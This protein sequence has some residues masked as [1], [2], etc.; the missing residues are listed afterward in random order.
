MK[1]QCLGPSRVLPLW[2]L[3]SF[4]S[5]FFFYFFS[6]FSFFVH[7]FIF[8]IFLMFFIFLVHFSEEKSF[9]FSFFLVFLSNMFYSRHQNQSLTVSSEVGAPKRC[10]VPDDKGR[11]SLDWVGGESMIQLPR[12]EWRILACENGASP[13]CI[14][15]VVVVVV[16]CC[17]K[18][19][20]VWPQIA[21]VHCAGALDG[22]E[23][24]TIE[25]SENWRSTSVRTDGARKMPHFTAKKPTRSE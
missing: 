24:F 17:W 8:L 10:G 15:V 12:V 9:F 16:C 1:N 11:D 3:F 19:R 4:F 6:F 7:F 14:I 25:G 13:E 2:A 18:S 21:E 20:C 22:E 23:L 5:Y